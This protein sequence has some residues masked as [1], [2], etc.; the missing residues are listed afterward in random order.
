[1]AQMI[2]GL[3]VLASSLM[4]KPLTSALARPAPC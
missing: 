3:G 2:G 1:V 4:L